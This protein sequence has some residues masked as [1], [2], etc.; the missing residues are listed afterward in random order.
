MAAAEAQKPVG[1]E[2]PVVSSGADTAQ[3]LRYRPGPGDAG[4][5]QRVCDEPESPAAGGDAAGQG[6]SGR[7]PPELLRS[8]SHHRAQACSAKRWV[9]AR[10]DLGVLVPCDSA[11]GDGNLPSA[12]QSVVRLS[13]RD[14]AAFLPCTGHC[15]CVDERG[16]Y[17]VDSLV[18]RSAE[19]PKCQLVF[20]PKYLS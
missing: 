13:T 6:C 20:L 2:L 18:S 15:W 3:C 14:K 17:V 16:R 1:V 5:S 8:Q 9:A 4:H 10:G 11:A 19:L 12:Q 7:V